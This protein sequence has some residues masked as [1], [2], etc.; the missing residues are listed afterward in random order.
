VNA[1]AIV[2]GA[3]LTATVWPDR[4]PGGGGTA[5]TPGIVVY[6]SP[7][8]GCCGKWIQH[9]RAAGFRVVVHETTDLRAVK[10]RYSVP[11]PLES[12]HT[13]VTAG[14]A[15]EGHVPADVVAR[16]LRERPAVAGIAVAGMPLGAPGM[17]GPGGQPYDVAAFRR[18][19]GWSVY[20]R[21]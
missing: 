16:L 7:T 12:C 18:E 21:R 2:I 15:I 17:E 4:A 9:L 1:I 5:P 11:Q 19:G 8:C 20:E 6:K 10:T 14:Y 3:L 13:A